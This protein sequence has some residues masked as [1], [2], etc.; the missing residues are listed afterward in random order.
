MLFQKSLLR[1]LR[2]AFGGVFAVLI[3]TL[4]TVVLIRTLGRAAAGRVDSDLVFPLIVFNALNFMSAALTLA[5]YVSIILVL[6]R[7]WRDSEAVVWLSAGKGL[8]DFF[9]PIWRFLWPLLI[10]V[11]TM[12]MVVAPWS[13]QKII[14]FEEEL[15]ARGDARRVTPGQ[16]RESY[17][18]STVFFVENPDSA[19]GRI[20]S[21]FVRSVQPGGGFS[22]VASST[23]RFE[24]DSESQPWVILERGYRADFTPGILEAR[25]TQFDV[26][27]LRSESNIP[28]ATSDLPIKAIPT[29][30]LVRRSDPIA[31]SE[32]VM[33]FGLPLLA[34]SLGLLALPMAIRSTRSTKSV[35]LILA[36]IIYLLS[37]NL[38][39]SFSLIVNQGL[40]SF[41]LAIWPLPSVLMLIAF[42]LTWQKVR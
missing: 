18:G 3:T 9:G 1:E 5:I 6:S 10:V 37:T 14:A 21:V 33:R 16:F 24:V 28:T 15:R 32:K 30:E 40:L 35:N 31:N 38:L 8:F 13:Q 7:W 12:S 26:Y 36:L 39:T 25:V 4:V 20:G 23:G 2:S 11:G 42:F 34:F 41:D 29:L 17:S 22:V 19:N 27:R